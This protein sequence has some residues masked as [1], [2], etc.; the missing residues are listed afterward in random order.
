MYLFIKLIIL[1]VVI[2]EHI[3]NVDLSEGLSPNVFNLATG[4]IITVN[5]TCGETGPE[6][7]CKLVEHVLKRPSDTTPGQCNI[8][9]AANVDISK[10]HPIANVIDGSESWWQSPTLQY[11]KKYEWIT[12]TLNLK[13]VYQISHVIIKSA[14][15]PLPG[16]WILEHSVDGQTYRPWQYF[17]L[18]DTECWDTYRIRPT[19]GKVRYRSDDEVICTS[20]YSKSDILENGEAHVSL[21]TGRP[22]AEG[23]SDTL[24]EFTKA[25]FVRLRLQKIKTLHSELIDPEKMDNAITRRFFYTIKDVTIGGQCLC[26]GHARECRASIGSALPKCQCEHNTSGTNCEICKPLF[27]QKKWRSASSSWGFVCNECQCFGHSEEC[28]YDQTIASKKLS[29]SKSG[30]YE[31]GGVCSKCRH[32]TVGINCEQCEDGY[33][34][35]EGVPLDS[36]NPCSKCQCSGPGI[37]HLCIKDVFHLI[38]GRKPGDCLCREGFEGNRCERC[39]PGYKN[40]PQCTQCTCVYAGIINTEVCDGQCLC[41]NNV[42][43]TRCNK[44]K[45]GYYN[46]DHDNIDGCAE[47]YCFGA[48]NICA[49][50]D[51][52]LEIV[53]NLDDWMIS[54]LSGKVKVPPTKETGRLVIANDEMPSS[55]QNLYYWEAPEDYLGQNLYS[56]G[57]DLKFHISYVV[58]RGDVSGYFTDDA[59]MI[60]EG[61]PDNIRIGYKWH[62]PSEVDEVNTTI[63]MPL[64]EK[65]WFRVGDDGKKTDASVSREE[66]TLVLYDLKRLLIRAKF[67]TDQI[68]GGLYQIDM[69]KASNTSKSIKKAEGT[70]KCE[71]P[72][73]YAGLS[74]QY[75]APGYRRVNNILVNGICEKCDCN[76]HAESCDP[77]TGKCS[78]CL[79]NTTGPN[80]GEC[81]PGFYGNATQGFEDDCKPCGCP[82]LISSNNFSPTCHYEPNSRYGYI[83][84]CPI[85]YIGDQCERCIEGYYGNPLVPGGLCL[86]CEC[87][88]ETNRSIP[89]WCDHITGHC[90]VIDEC[91]DL[92]DK[93]ILMLLEDMEFLKVL[94][95]EANLTDVA[96]LPWTRLL[97]LTNRFTKISTN[98]N[99]YQRVISRGNQI[100][101]NYSISFDLETWADIL[102]LKSRELYDRGPV[103]A[104]DAERVKNEAQALLDLLNELWT[105][106]IGIVNQLRKHHDP[107]GHISDR[108]LQEA[109]RILRELQAR[110]FR[111]RVEEADRELRKAKNLLER[112][113]QLL[114]DR[115]HTDPLKQ[116]LDRLAE[117]LRDILSIVQNKVQPPIQTTVKLVRE[118]YPV[119]AFI[120]AAVANSSRYADEA[121]ITLTEAHKLLEA[122]KNA[123]IEAVVTYD[124]LPRLLAKVDNDTQMIEERRGILAR[125]NPEY[126]DKYVIP[127]QKH[128]EELIRQVN[129]LNGLFN[130]TRDVAEYPLKAA[131]VYQKIV[132]ALA[133]AENAAKKANEAAERAYKEAYPGTDEALTLKAKNAKLRSE[134]LLQQAKEFRDN[135]VPEL[136]RELAKKKFKLDVIADDLANGKRNLDLINKALDT[137]PKDLSGILRGV[138]AK[139]RNI[140]DGLEDIHRRI[141]DID[142]RI[143]ADLMPKLNRLR[144]GTTS[145][146]DNLTKIIDE[147]RNDIRDG[148]RLADRAEE[149]A[150]RVNRLHNQME[151]NFKELKDRILLARQKAASIRVS[152][153]TDRSGVCARS[154]EAQIEPSVSN[155]IILNYAIKDEARDALLF[156]IGNKRTDDFMAIE[157]VDRKI[158]YI[159]NA[160]GGTKM[161]AH[162]LNIETNDQQLLKDSQWYKIEVN[163]IRNEA[164]LSVK[165]IPDANKLDPFEI[166]DTSPEGFNRMDLNRD[167]NFFIGEFPPDFRPP[168]EVRT[169]S[170]A[171]CLY[172]LTLDGK[173]VGLWNFTTNKGCDGCK[174][175][176]T[177]PKDLS[178]FLFKGEDSYVIENQIRRYDKK[179]FLVSLQFKT[180]DE[181]ALLFFTANPSTGDY[182]AIY[183]KEGKVIY[184][185]N[186][187]NSARLS[188]TT[189]NKYNTGQWVRLN[190]EREKL[191]GVLSVDEEYLEGRIPSGSPTNMELSDSDLYLGGV[192]PN[193]TAHHWPNIVF[194]SFLGCIKDPQID[195]T[196]LNLLQQEAF[197]VEVGCRE[198][199][200]K[201]V[202]FKGSGYLQLNSEP[203]KEDADFSF[204]FKTTQDEALLLL[205]TFEGTRGPRSRDSHYYSLSIVNGILEA[206]FNGGVGETI[207]NAELMAVNDGAYHTVSVSKKVRKIILSLDDKEIGTTRL[208]RGTKDIDAPTTGGLYLGGLPQGMSL[209]GMAGTKESLKGVIRDAVFNG[210]LLRLNE[211]VSFEGVGIGRESEPLNRL[212]DN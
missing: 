124:I 32:H 138:E 1:T 37:S 174:E 152:L 54:D 119:T 126:N 103:L 74:C 53:N 179:K 157:M 65:G 47:C 24:R 189:K 50:S 129:F 200:E 33:Y 93:C 76:N 125:L 80:C 34:R 115:K 27:N 66:F 78:P 28:Y 30:V 149:I 142:R 160:G 48:T 70:E 161:L 135:K 101:G 130:A 145:G 203:L 120:V 185:F 112:V 31:G 59:D 57:N 11:G 153:G 159:W 109:E 58:S 61:G 21:I 171:G 133:A 168:R 26:N 7:Y 175:G 43:G 123:L 83:C 69:E 165:R 208:A 183:L 114:T 97:H 10:R 8:C 91:A 110:D 56:Y 64:R 104:K 207:L 84:N 151:L 118:S 187:A 116:R 92:D 40:Y 51:W 12:I 136:E 23:P 102:Y 77:F 29:L 25:Q 42:V 178:T 177:E 202:S 62:K 192:T 67:H 131:N 111:P 94:V 20:F 49:S 144:A 18:S 85:G 186:V 90:R 113:R 180:F 209:K 201:V 106:I 181:E 197:G 148:S 127:C 193:F 156:F 166:S 14:I 199:T 196:P 96:N 188:L 71:C 172:E 36:P 184:Q 141:D 68:E 162:T 52:G 139:L 108:M 73:G 205:S 154:Y 17:A 137:L 2:V 147:A 143:A 45:S 72:P 46:L 63:I 35:P 9:D 100:I 128:A 176:A 190:A 38:E 191:D 163:R 88:P 81:L 173:P 4:A 211:P 206:R 13:Q 16:N 158:R 150:E 6:Y 5:A 75:C 212:V 89:G 39:A 98:F 167:S 164:I 87:G 195:T 55:A 170:F 169:N 155:N 105:M 19:I 107:I 95:E 122:A 182:L 210:K 134:E 146:L 194:K 99:D 22:G 79:H 15:S 198:K 44:C 86:P 204:T 132:D 41:K 60:L 140:L 3:E 82:L 121:N 117:L